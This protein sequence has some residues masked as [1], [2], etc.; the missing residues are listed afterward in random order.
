MV[1]VPT[2]AR[3]TPALSTS[4]KNENAMVD[5]RMSPEFP[6]DASLT[7]MGAT[8]DW[9]ESNVGGA[10]SRET[11]QNRRA[12]LDQVIVLLSKIICFLAPI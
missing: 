5:N 8:V 1:V 10:W 9:L 12:G 6:S 4:A 7:Q 11:K 3:A 2:R